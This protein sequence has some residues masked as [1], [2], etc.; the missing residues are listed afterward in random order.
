LRCKANY[1]LHCA[2]GGAASFGLPCVLCCSGDKPIHSTDP[3]Q[4]NP[5]PIW[6][7]HRHLIIWMSAIYL[8]LLGVLVFMIDGLGDGSPII[9][10]LL[11]GPRWIVAVPLIVLAPLA[12]LARSYWATTCVLLGGLVIAGPITGGT[13]NVGRLFQSDRPALQ[14]IRVVTWNMGSAKAGP[15]F[16][17]FLAE[18]APTLLFCQESN[19][20]VGDL[21]AGWKVVGL[22]GNRVATR[23]PIRP[24][25]FLDLSSI[26][27]AGRLDR[28]RVETTDGEI[29]LVNLHLPTPRPGIETAI[30]TKLQDLSELRRIIEIRAAASRAARTWI[31]ESSSNMI[32][33][34]DFNM[35]VESRIYRDNWS[36]FSNAFSRMGL[37][38]GTTKQ[39][40]WFGI[41]IDHILFMPAWR[42]RKAWVG[43]TMGSDHRPLVADLVMEDH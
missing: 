43:P 5:K 10:L 3:K 28:F 19:L 36:G 18:T 35:P 6:A 39:T 20:V 13:V 23:L 34:G 15:P 1:F 21:P 4:N 24:D 30:G 9:T 11:F 2:K 31:G 32:L 33:A 37:G 26:G 12:I 41:R 42:C 22:A 17:R 29:V 40:R 8:L 16:E 14:N 27:A 7:R 38:W 25:G